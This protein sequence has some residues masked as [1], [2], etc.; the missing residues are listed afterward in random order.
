[1]KK[2]Y[3]NAFFIFGIAVLVV[4]V[5]QL[6]FAQVLDGLSL[7]YG[8]SCTCSTPRHGTLSLQALDAA[9]AGSH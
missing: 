1:M 8:Y 3:Q 6:D 2:K 5:T 9:T 4:M 7:P